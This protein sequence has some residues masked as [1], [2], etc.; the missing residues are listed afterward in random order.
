MAGERD[1]LV[2]PS[3]NLPEM[4][5]ALKTA[6]RIVKLPGLNHLLQPARTGSP[7]EY[8]KIDQTMAPEAMEVIG[9]WIAAR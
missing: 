5:R 8:A 1:P 2:A 3:A 6:Y 4:A 9:K 7:M